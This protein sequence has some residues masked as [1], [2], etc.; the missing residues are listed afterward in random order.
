MFV[1][2]NHG[3]SPAT[4]VPKTHGFS[5]TKADTENHGI[6]SL[7]VVIT[8]ARRVHLPSQPGSPVLGNPTIISSYQPRPPCGPGYRPS[9]AEPGATCPAPLVFH[10]LPTGDLELLCLPRAGHR[11]PAVPAW[12]PPG[13]EPGQAPLPSGPHCTLHEG[14]RGWAGSRQA[15]P[16]ASPSGTWACP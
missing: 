11:P 3:A 6:S 15:L 13:W 2:K 16:P 5:P 8:S 14:P 10:G 7:W 12:S 9:Q 1:A 4:V